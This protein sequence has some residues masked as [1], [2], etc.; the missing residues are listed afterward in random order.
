MR[1][2]GDARVGNGAGGDARDEGDDPARATG[3]DRGAVVV[4]D[5]RAGGRVPATGH[6]RGVGDRHAHRRRA[7]AGGDRGG[8]VADIEGH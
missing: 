5:D 6:G 1:A 3:G 2:A 8:G 4:E 7:G